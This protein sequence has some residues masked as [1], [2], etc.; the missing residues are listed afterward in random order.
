M[1]TVGQLQKVHTMGFEL[2][3]SGKAAAAF[4]RRS[5]FPYLLVHVQD[6]LDIVSHFRGRVK[7]AQKTHPGIIHRCD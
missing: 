3:L 7:H 2:F 1:R 5:E 6:P 4:Q